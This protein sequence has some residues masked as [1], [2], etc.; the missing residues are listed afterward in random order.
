MLQRRE[1]QGL[2]DRYQRYGCLEAVRR[3]GMTTPEEVSR[4]CGLPMRDVLRHLQAL[5]R[6]AEIVRDGLSFRIA[7]QGAAPARVYASFA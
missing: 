6:D 7:P 1:A 2:V 5:E 4:W 3:K